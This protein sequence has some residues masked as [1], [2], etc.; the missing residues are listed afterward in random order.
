[1]PGFLGRGGRRVDSPRERAIAARIDQ[2]AATD[3]AVPR[4]LSIHASPFF[5]DTAAYLRAA[6]GAPAWSRRLG[7]I[8]R[9]EGELRE[10]L[11]AALAEYRRRS[12][13]RPLE[14]ASAWRAYVVD[15]D[16]SE[17]NDLV[18]K[19]NLYY[20]IEAGLR[21][22]WPS[23]R[24]ILPEGLQFPLPRLTHEALLAEFPP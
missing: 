5:L 21:M 7:R 10:H 2:A 22:Q 6:A 13:G 4:P 1:M 12:D 19:H 14:L 3:S 8:Q 23:G 15:L 9:L 18:D 20:P 11:G 17:L 16:L 24:Y